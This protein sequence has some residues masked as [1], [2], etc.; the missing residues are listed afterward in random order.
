M[1]KMKRAGDAITDADI[2]R[3]RL[4][5]A[6]EMET[7]LA[8]SRLGQAEAIGA[9]GLT[10]WEELHETFKLCEA[11]LGRVRNSRRVKGY[12][13]AARERIAVF[14]NKRERHAWQ[15]T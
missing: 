7:A 3:L 12:K 15:A 8:R 13:S 11:A 5:L 1:T 9:A 4:D 10:S 6:R 14:L 2:Q